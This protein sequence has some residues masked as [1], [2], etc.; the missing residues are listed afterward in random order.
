[1]TNLD[2]SNES[3]GHSKTA[4]GCTGFNDYGLKCADLLRATE[5][6]FGSVIQKRTAIERKIY[7][8]HNKKSK[9][10]I[11]MFCLTSCQLNV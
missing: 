6:S 2:V 10:R 9:R 4:I 11:L 1:M 7:D 5:A 3:F 8:G